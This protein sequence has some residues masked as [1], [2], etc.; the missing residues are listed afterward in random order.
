MCGTF[1]GPPTGLIPWLSK[2]EGN[3][4]ATTAASPFPLQ[5]KPMQ[6]QDIARRISGAVAGEASTK[7]SQD[8][9]SRQRAISGVIAGE[10]FAQVKIY[11]VPIRN[12]SPSH[13]HYLPFASHFPLP[14]FTF[15]FSS[16]SFPYVSLFVFPCAF[17]LLASLLA[18]NL[19]IWIHL[20]CSTWIIFDP[21]ALVLK[22]QLAWLM[23]NL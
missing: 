4:Y 23:G 17:Y 22:P 13:L 11:Q 1:E 16:P 14:H 19:L 7:S 12:S 9:T 21:Y 2:I 15:A 18:K 3:T 10:V 6:A 5:G 20:K 8:P